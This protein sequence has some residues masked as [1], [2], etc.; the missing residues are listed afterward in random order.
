MLHQISLPLVTD[1]EKKKKEEERL[2]ILSCFSLCVP[3][4]GWLAK[5]LTELQ[6]PC[7]LHLH[8]L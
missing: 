5:Y 2:F 8:L 7:Q 6:W 4:H 1:V 3:L